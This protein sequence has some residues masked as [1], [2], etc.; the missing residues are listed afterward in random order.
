M[1]EATLAAP[2]SPATQTEQPDTQGDEV[3][4]DV[5]EFVDQRFPEATEPETVEEQKQDEETPPPV[6][7]E[8][9]AAIEAK[10]ALKAQELRESERAQEAAERAKAE[11]E[12]AQKERDQR[13]KS[14][15]ANRARAMR[16]ELAKDGVP[17][18][19]INA[20]VA[21]LEAH[22]AISKRIADE[23]VKEAFWTSFRDVAAEALPESERKGFI[24]GFKIPET[25]D[26]VRAEIEGLKATWTKGY[27]SPA[28][29]KAGETA[30]VLLYKRK[31]QEAGILPESRSPTA[32]GGG[33]SS[34]IH[35][36]NDNDVAFNE[37]RI[38]AAQWKANA[39]RLRR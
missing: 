25:A 36:A 2:E 27:I 23:E 26:E 39:D 16:A 4:A 35:N 7:D 8:E 17:D 32:L 33:G 15:F 10:A 14:D 38:S 22:H 21:Q 24:D 37:G 9:L 3:D 1:A 30:A 18:D 20:H 28:Q 5:R 19:R 11:T 34:A 31:Q 13:Q 12:K 6:E 29:Q